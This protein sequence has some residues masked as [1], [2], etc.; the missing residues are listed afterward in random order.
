MYLYILPLKVGDVLIVV[1]WAYE[2]N[3][4]EDLVPVACTL[5]VVHVGHQL[6]GDLHK[7]LLANHA[8]DQVQRSKTDG[9]V[10]IV[11]TLNNQVSGMK[12]IS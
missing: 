3:L 9:V 7:V 4:W 11:E 1:L 12:E 6:L 5:R 2:D 8:S 10:T